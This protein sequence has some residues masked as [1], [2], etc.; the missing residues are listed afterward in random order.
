V[1]RRATLCALA[2]LA[3]AL[4][5]CSLN[6]E[7]SS[8][9]SAGKP[10]A[11]GTP[12]TGVK[13]DEKEAAA[14][15]GFPNV[16]TKNTTRVSGADAA[17]DVAGAVSAVYPATSDSTRPKV[18]A[19]VDQDDWQA[20]L[21]ASVLSAAP[22]HAPMRVSDGSALPAV[23]DDTLK[24]LDPKGA[25]LTKGAQVVLIGS[26]PRAPKG[27][28]PANLGGK[29]T[30]PYAV[31]AAVDRFQSAA[32]GEPSRNVIVTSGERAPYAMPAGAWAARSGDSILLVKQ[33]EI[34]APTQ[35]AL[36]AHQKPNIY[37]LGP[38]EA[39]SKKVEASLAKFGKVK[40][41]SGPTPVENAIAF[42]RFQGSGDFGWGANVPGFNVT[43]ASTERPLDIAASAALGGN[44][45]FAPLLLTDEPDP[46][47]RK[48]DGY[49][50]DVQP[51]F[52]G[53]PRDGVYNHV[54]ILGD[55]K[56]IAPGV[57]GRVDEVTALVPVEVPRQ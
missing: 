33:N 37:I 4:P 48:L 23:T 5:G 49:F 11:P 41:I 57:Q 43:L 56:T 7:K 30:D 12:A 40:R 1:P 34:P 3:L 24:R 44:G 2:A 21:A 39:V 9:G 31:A 10:S 6:D 14:Q 17:S 53:D 18:V 42:A 46:L 35:K 28:K 54:W 36:A 45:I 20:A 52:E 25:D 29:T 38:A 47:P 16:A 19:L 32:K 27:L 13:S 51:G 26:K 55:T 8:G 50:L 22:V 15:L